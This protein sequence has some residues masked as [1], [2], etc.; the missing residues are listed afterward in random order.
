MLRRKIKSCA[1]LVVVGTE[2]AATRQTIAD[3]VR[4]FL[5][6]GRSSSV[7][8]V[9]FGGAVYRA[10]WY[11][12]VEGIAP[13]PEK[14]PEALDD[15]EPSP[16]VLSRIE[17]QFNYT[18]RN[19][20]LRRSAIGMA[21]VFAVLLLAG[22]GAGVYAKQQIVLANAERERAGKARALADAAQ[23]DAATERDKAL[24]A[25]AS[26][27]RATCSRLTASPDAAF[28]Q[29]AKGEADEQKSLA[30]KA[31]T[32]TGVEPVSLP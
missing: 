20:R 31:A 13:E 14:N 27:S 12:L 30:E 4:E 9:D 26:N 28:S 23:R 18:R 11:P 21:V 32:G 29:A 8:P 22:V 1:M 15:G 19:Q 17:K 5:Q 3:E 24:A 25:F 7:V 2:R 16:S 10:N 6:T